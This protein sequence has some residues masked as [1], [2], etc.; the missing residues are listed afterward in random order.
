MATCKDNKT[1]FLSPFSVVFEYGIR[2]KKSG[3]GSEIRLR[4]R[5][6]HPGSATLVEGEG[7]FMLRFL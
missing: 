2:G 6:K 1:K 4:I 5:D 7:Q 3:S